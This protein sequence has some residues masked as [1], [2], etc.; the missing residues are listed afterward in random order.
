MKKKFFLGV[1][2]LIICLTIVIRN[3]DYTSQKN[4]QDSFTSLKESSNSNLVFYK[5]NCP[6]CKG[7]EK[8]VLER[9]KKSVA[10]TFFVDAESANGKSLAQKYHVRYAATVIKIRDGK[11]QK[12]VYAEKQNDTYRAKEDVINKV[13]GGGR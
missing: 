6:Y 2:F 9:S 12:Y 8:E 11:V 10:P 1:T 13:F 7:A 5:K 3:N 4:N